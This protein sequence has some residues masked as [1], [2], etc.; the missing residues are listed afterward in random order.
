MEITFILLALAVCATWLRP[1]RLGSTISIPPW[2]ALFLFS[3]AS[4]YLAHIV[5]I[6]AIAGLA[7]FSLFAYLAA[8]ANTSRPLKFI[9]LFFI[10]NL[11]LVLA[12]H[13]WPGFHNP[14]LVADIRF[15]AD[16]PAVTHYANFD[17]AA[18]GLILLAFLCKRAG[19]LSDWKKVLLTA[20]PLA[21]FGSVLV[22]GIAMASGF[23]KPD[24]KLPDYT[25]IFL[26][27]NLLFTCV[28][29]E[30]F[31]RGFLQ[32]RMLQV[33]DGFRFAAPTAIA[34]SA[35]LFGAAHIGGGLT[36]AML[37][38]VAGLVYAY[39][40]HA[41]RRVEVAIIVHFLVNAV[42]FVGFTYPHLQ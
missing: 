38:T 30:T 23:V 24:L 28:A 18:V 35:L 11:A 5:D 31:F 22:L 36:Y 21:L 4:A 37:A 20:L 41:T 1:I 10:L 6:R 33:L 25:P 2:Q 27:A 9:Y 39:A 17:K 32:E 12:L 26:L 19:D 3:T 42:H 16:A 13:G 34:V 40:Y 8:R 29:E 7:I 14:V 15:S